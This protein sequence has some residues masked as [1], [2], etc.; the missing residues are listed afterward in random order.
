[1]RAKQIV[2]HSVGTWI[3]YEFMCLARTEGLQQPKLFLLSSMP[4]PDIPLTERPW[5]RQSDL[6]EQEFIVRQWAL[7]WITASL[8]GTD[9]GNEC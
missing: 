8:C 5:R 6:S 7:H 9:P 1:M 2:A 3:A 4:S